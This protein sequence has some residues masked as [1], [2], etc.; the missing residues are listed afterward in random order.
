MLASLLALARA[1]VD[2][3][4]AEVSVGDEGAHLEFFCQGR[5]L[6]EGLVRRRHIRPG[7]GRATFAEDPQSFGPVPRS[8]RLVLARL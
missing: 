4:E 6:L 5:R 7:A 1:E 3:A 8:P 2:I